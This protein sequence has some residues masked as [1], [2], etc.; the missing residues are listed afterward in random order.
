ML[1]NDL[2]KL[3]WPQ[4]KPGNTMSALDG[5][6]KEAQTGGMDLNVYVL[7]FSSISEALVNGHALYIARMLDGLS[8][9]L[10]HKVIRHCVK[11]K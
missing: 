2:R 7:K 11:Q 9:D 6:V 3:Y 5:I 1:Q 8:E 10:S 4:N